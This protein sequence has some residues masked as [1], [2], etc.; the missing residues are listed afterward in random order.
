LL[1]ALIQEVNAMGNEVKTVPTF[2]S[3]CEHNCGMEVTVKDGRIEEIRGLEAHVFSRG[4]LC[5]KGKAAKEFFSSPDRLTYPLR[6]KGNDW[7]R[8]SWDEALDLIASRLRKLKQDYGAQSLIIYLGHTY[9]KM[10]IAAYLAKKFSLLYGTPNVCSAVS[11]CFAPTLLS[12]LFTFGGFALPDFEKSR[13]V[14]IWGANPVASGAPILGNP[15]RVAQVFQEL[16]KKGTKFMVI[17]PRKTTLANQADEFIQ[18][19]PGTD[20]ALALGMIRVIIDEGLYDK[21]FVANHTSGFDALKEFIQGYHL[22]KVEEITRVPREHIVKAARFYATTKP[23]CIHHGSGLEH[24]TNG[25]QSIRALHILHAI[26]GNIDVKGGNCFIHVSLFAQPNIIPPFKPDEIIGMKE[27]PVFV[28]FFKQAQAMVLMD[29]LLEQKPNSLKGMLVTGGNPLLTWANSGKARKA[30]EKLEFLVVLDLFMT[31]TAKKA[32]F[33]LPAASFLERDELATLPLNMQR[34]VLEY[35]ECW[36]DWKFWYE[37]AKRMGYSDQFPW[38]SADEIMNMLLEPTNLTCDDL[39]KRPEGIFAPMEYGT[40][41]KKGFNTYSGRVEIFCK[42]LEASGY[43][44]LP[45]YHDPEESVRKKSEVAKDYPLTL[46]TGSRVPMF[47]H[48]TLRTVPSLK[49][50]HPEPYVE[51]HPRIAEKIMV[52]EGD[53]VKVE[54]LRGAVTVKAKVT[55]TIL[56]QVAHLLHG[57]AE[58][59]CNLLTDNG[60]R[61]P[62]SGF[63]ALKSSLCRVRKA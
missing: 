5:V 55:D 63:P 25:V 6:R 22:E 62:I 9:V 48:S 19:H 31:E 24:H 46:I 27:H 57:W 51:I 33:V 49:K 40:L 14:V 37:L 44:P 7:E 47:V 20:G 11:E 43:N 41:R 1:R 50:L 28:S 30:F 21:E 42:S 10:A 34:K 26:T 53:L 29:A 18:I 23:A 54:S 17:D 2:C 38:K 52:K 12:N 56:P 35:E 32:D 60:V 4:N 15:V 3:L 36:P 61:D 39:K 16:K 13:L 58:A 59:D 45:E 8:I